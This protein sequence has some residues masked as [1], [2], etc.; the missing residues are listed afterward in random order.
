M[1]ILDALNVHYRDLNKI[2]K[3]L[4]NSGESEIIL[5]NV[6]GQRYIGAGAKGNHKLIIEGIPGNDMA[7]Y[8]DG[9]TISI[10]GNAQDAV[11]NTMNSGRIIVYGNAGDIVGYAMRG[12]EIFILGDVGYRVGIHMKEY[13]DKKP[14]IVIG[15]KAGDF[16]GEYMAG[17]IIIILGLNTSDAEDS[18]GNFCGIGMHG[19]TIYVRKHVN[20]NKL[21]K[22]VIAVEASMEDICIIAGYV[23][24]FSHFF[25][26][27]F[28]SVMKEKF[29]KLY[30]HDSRPYGKLYAY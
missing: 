29:I 12:G 11:G 14:V 4:I 21:G 2:V 16:L 28:H 24:K 7:A 30:A 23:K 6:H 13:E 25:N 3:E 27:D 18:I 5:K 15:G 8:M 17:G 20:I 19:G 26:I 9:L 10:K 1:R 22:E